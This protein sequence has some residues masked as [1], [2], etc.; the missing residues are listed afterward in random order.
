MKT[1]KM[2]WKN[3]ISARIF[4]NAEMCSS[5][6]LNFPPAVYILGWQNYRTRICSF[7]LMQE[8]HHWVLFFK[9]LQATA[10]HTG[11]IQGCCRP[12]GDLSGVL[13]TSLWAW[14]LGT[15]P[16]PTPTP[17][18]EGDLLS[19]ENC[20]MTGVGPTGMRNAKM[21]PKRKHILLSAWRHKPQ[22]EQVHGVDTI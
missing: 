16:E 21:E 12:Q 14:R 2:C 1:K 11:S 7:D 3:H 4:A 9:P 18:M 8:K 17:P 19:L 10:E 6:P 22:W 5:L 15:E 13:W 20:M